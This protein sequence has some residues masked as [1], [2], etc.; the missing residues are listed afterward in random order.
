MPKTYTSNLQEVGDAITT[1][2]PNQNEFIS[3][4]INR[5][6]L[7]LFKNMSY[8]NPLKSLKRGTL[9]YGESIEE[10]FVGL[11]KSYDYNWA[12]DQ[13]EVNP[14]KREVP[15]VK[16]YFHQLNVQKVFKST[17]TEAEISLAFTS[18]MGVFNLVEKIIDSIFTAYEVFEW[19]KTKELLKTAYTA[20]D[21][22]KI[23]VDEAVDEVTAKEMIKKARALSSKLTMPSTAYNKAGV[24]NTTRRE[25]QLIIMTADLEALVDVDVLASAFNMS[26]TEFLGNRIIIDEFPEGMEDVQIM[27]MDRD[28]FMI[29]DKLLRM[30]SIYNPAQ[31]YWNYF[32]HYWGVYSYSLVEN[33]VAF[34]IS[35]GA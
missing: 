14:F 19:N 25:D 32:L 22:V 30:E 2:L 18:D 20:N 31:M 21:I 4:L 33:C 29:Y 10:I 12:G 28:W 16:A 23:E 13:D 8:T 26:K 6:G 15:D 7:V 5:I 11:A 34:V 27:I 24:T 35:Q 3:A 17:T 1:F 9:Q